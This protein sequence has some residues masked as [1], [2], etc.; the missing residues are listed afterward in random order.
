M[1]EKLILKNLECSTADAENIETIFSGGAMLLVKFQDWAEQHW[2]IKFS[3][4][5]AF[6]WNSEELN[7]R[8]INDDC[9]YEVQNSDWISRYKN[10]GEPIETLKHYKCCFNAYGILDVIFEE[11][12]IDK[13]L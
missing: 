1:S 9:V 8:K 12:K 2:K 6:S 7:Y 3:E 10:I 4:V 5:L 13:V 11:I